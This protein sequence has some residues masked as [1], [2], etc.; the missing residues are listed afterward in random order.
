MQLVLDLN[1]GQY[2]YTV[3][4]LIFFSSDLI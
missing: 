2:M 1:V 4:T 3:Y